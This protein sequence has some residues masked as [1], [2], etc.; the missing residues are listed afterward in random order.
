[1]QLNYSA[2]FEHRK[3]LKKKGITKFIIPIEEYQSQS[4]EN[5][6]IFIFLAKH[7]IITGIAPN[8]ILRNAI[9]IGPYEYVAILI[10]KKAEAQIKANKI[11]SR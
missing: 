6:S 4:F 11:K 10:L 5:A 8:K 3:Q 9:V 7:R 2:L 1:M